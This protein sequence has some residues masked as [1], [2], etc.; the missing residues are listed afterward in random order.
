MA[1]NTV[2]KLQKDKKRIERLFVMFDEKFVGS[3]FNDGN[4]HMVKASVVFEDTKLEY[5]PKKFYR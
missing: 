1:M 5:G 3:Q 4:D 2:V